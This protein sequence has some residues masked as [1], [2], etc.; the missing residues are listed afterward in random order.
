MRPIGTDGEC[1][2]IAKAI[3]EIHESNESVMIR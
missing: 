2:G 1:E 3:Q